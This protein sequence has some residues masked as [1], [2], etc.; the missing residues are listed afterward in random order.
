MGGWEERLNHR[1]L[2]II[3][4]DRTATLD[5]IGNLAF[6]R[7]PAARNWQPLTFSCRDG[8]Q[9]MAVP[10]TMHDDHHIT[11]AED[12]LFDKTMKIM[13]VVSRLTG[14]VCQQFSVCW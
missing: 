12:A 13:G 7:V 10:M 6:C 8:L 4:Y 9:A 14:V 11:D 5:K 1:A 2:P 3:T